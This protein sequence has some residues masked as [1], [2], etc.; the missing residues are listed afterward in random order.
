MTI[1]DEMYEKCNV[2]AYKAYLELLSHTISVAESYV[3][4]FKNKDVEDL[5]KVANELLITLKNYKNT[6]E[7]LLN[8]RIIS[9]IME[10]EKDR[11]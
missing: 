9:F 8:Q 10:K 4:R 5:H 2:S 6:V 1:I 7:H 3:L 11:T